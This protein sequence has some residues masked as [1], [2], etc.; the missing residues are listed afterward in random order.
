MAGE[1][2]R[3]PSG[4]TPDTLK[5]LGETEIGALRDSILRE[6]RRIDQALAAADRALA[7]FE[8]TYQLD[9][10]KQN[11]FRGSLSDLSKEMA[12]RRELESSSAALNARLDD[13]VNQV[14]VLR[15][16]LDVG[17]IGLA[18]IQNSLAH[19]SGRES[20]NSDAT[21]RIFAVVGFI[22]ALV[23]IAVSIVIA[24]TAG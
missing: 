1:T 12:T 4:W 8:A 20:A 3:S 10:A 11:E 21:A 18:Q 17:P 24:T 7:K 16:R 2:E 15:S 13:L 9:S 19:E 23:A 14:G 22:I 6:V 5:I